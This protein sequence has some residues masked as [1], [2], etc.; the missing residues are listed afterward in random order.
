[1]QEIS[2]DNALLASI[3]YVLVFAGSTL[4]SVHMQSGDHLA[5]GTVF[6]WLA[7]LAVGL[8]GIA[9]L[10]V[11]RDFRATVFYGVPTVA[12][13]IAVALMAP[14]TFTRL[15]SLVLYTLLIGVLWYQQSRTRTA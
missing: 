3:F 8:A 2:K 10:I 1:M 15:L 6:L 9:Y 4:L 11:A 5:G 7:P 12:F 14:S 13:A